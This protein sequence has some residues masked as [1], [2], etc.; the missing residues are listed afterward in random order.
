MPRE[1]DNLT[2][3]AELTEDSLLSS[4]KKRYDEG[5]V[6]TDVGDILVSLNPFREVPI[7]SAECSGMYAVPDV[8]H[9]APHIFRSASRAFMAMLDC[10]KDQV[11]VISGE[12]GAGKTEAAK[13]LMRQ[14]S[15]AQASDHGACI[16]LPQANITNQTMSYFW[17]RN[18]S[19]V[20]INK[21]V[22]VTHAIHVHISCVDVLHGVMVTARFE[23]LVV[24]SVYLHDCLADRILLK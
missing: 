3:L 1:L 16:E 21:S 9:L 6:Y 11:F 17:W 8:S 13:L 18:E 7:Y 22:S 4:V 20:I 10:R 24:H 2:E 5:L 23:G 14:V 12:S 15:T 19:L